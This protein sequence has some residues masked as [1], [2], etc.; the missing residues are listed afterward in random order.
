[1]FWNLFSKTLN[2][3]GSYV[4]S[5]VF[6][7]SVTKKTPPYRHVARRRDQASTA[8]A[9]MMIPPSTIRW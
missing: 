8:T 6:V 7:T 2:V 3:I 9:M 5:V 4:W 1:M